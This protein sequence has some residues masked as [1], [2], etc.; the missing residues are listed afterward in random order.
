MPR[1][2]VGL[3]VFNGENF[4]SEAIESMLNQTFDDFELIISDNASTD[5]TEAICRAHAERDS[6]IRYIR[7]AT[8]RG[9]AWNQNEVMR[10]ARGE[11]FK[12]A[13]HDDL[14]EP[15]FLA[16]CVEALDAH[17]ECVLAYTDTFEMVRGDRSY[18]MQWHDRINTSSPRA[19]VRFRALIE[20]DIYAFR[21]FGVIRTAA[22]RRTPLFGHYHAADHVLI[23]H[24]ALL[25]P[26]VRVPENLFLYRIH[27]EQSINRDDDPR[28]Y[29]S[30]WDG[31]NQSGPI[32]PTWRYMTEL[33]KAVW[34]APLPAAERVR[35]LRHLAAWGLRKRT[36]LATELFKLRPQTPR[37][38]TPR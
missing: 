34:S 10:Q 19:H 16:R 28:A 22:L 7:Q 9:A 38:S 35:C 11:L 3:A 20:G 1:V 32:F 37:W 30:W 13:A 33:H 2:S 29:A 23:S 27:P 6:R 18:L 24:L 21:I 8:N 25:G 15:E 26:F 14:C 31:K 17:P 12:L 4:L 36:L 5:S